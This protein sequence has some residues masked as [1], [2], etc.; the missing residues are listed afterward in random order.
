MTDKLAY[1]IAEAA[2]AL[3]ISASVLKQELYE[4][5]IY[6]VKFGTRRVVPRWA[7]E[8]RLGKPDAVEETADG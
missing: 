6:S 8:Q 4:G 3:G 7:L 2:Y 5:R 1:S